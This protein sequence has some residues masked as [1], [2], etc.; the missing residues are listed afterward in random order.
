MA[1]RRNH[2]AELDM[3]LSQTPRRRSR[4]CHDNNDARRDDDYRP[5]RHN[6]H[7]RSNDDYHRGFYDNNRRRHDHHNLHPV[8]QSSGATLVRHAD[9]TGTTDIS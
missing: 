3:E 6:N 5:T 4:A 7:G 1:E 8:T 2:K 9:R